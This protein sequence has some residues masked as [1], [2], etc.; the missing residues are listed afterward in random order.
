MQP[1]TSD[2]Y[3]DDPNLTSGSDGSDMYEKSSDSGGNEE[4]NGSDDSLTYEQSSDSE[5]NNDTDDDDEPD[6][7]IKQSSTSGKL[8]SH[9]LLL[10]L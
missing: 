6:S 4:A 9:Y 8:E 7:N 5:G 10:T 1:Q 3:T 2:S